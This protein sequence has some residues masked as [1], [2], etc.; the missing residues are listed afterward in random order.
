MSYTRGHLNAFEDAVLNSSKVPDQQI[1]S[2]SVTLENALQ[3]ACFHQ[4]RHFKDLFTPVLRLSVLQTPFTENKS[5]GNTNI[6]SEE[7]GIKN[8]RTHSA[9]SLSVLDAARKCWLSQHISLQTKIP[10]V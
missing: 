4:I 10:T 5:G 3:K 7:R 1:F 8:A 6:L 2:R 9:F